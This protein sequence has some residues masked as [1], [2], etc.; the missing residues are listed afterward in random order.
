M[1]GVAGGLSRRMFLSGGAAVALLLA[2]P[3]AWARSA[4]AA[5]TRPLRRSRFKPVLG[6]T[7]RMTGGG[8]DVD[9]VLA[10]IT[11]LS[12]VLRADDEDRF[13][14]LLHARGSHRLRAGTKTLRHHDLGAVALF[15]SPVDRGVEPAHYEAVINR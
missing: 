3:P 11:D 15:I 2:G 10:E 5:R 14:L 7:L 1:T 9:V 6:A 8:D 4:L 12:P 13:A